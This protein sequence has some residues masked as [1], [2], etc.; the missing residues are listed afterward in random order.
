MTGHPDALPPFAS[1]AGGD[2]AWI[3]RPS[4]ISNSHPSNRAT[5]RGP[6]PSL[7]AYLLPARRTDWS[8]LLVS[9]ALVV[10]AGLALLLPD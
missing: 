1:A 4:T 5:Q 3:G 10:I 8:S 6:A 9:I 7:P 2:G